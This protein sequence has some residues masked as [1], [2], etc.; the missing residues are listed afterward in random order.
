MPLVQG[1]A[2]SEGHQ[3][4]NVDEYLVRQRCQQLYNVCQPRYGHALRCCHC[5]KAAISD[6]PRRLK[7]FFVAAA[8]INSCH[9]HVKCLCRIV[10]A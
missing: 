7:V 5:C 10:P 6:Q 1:P 3:E 8:K 2:V 9:G 4:T